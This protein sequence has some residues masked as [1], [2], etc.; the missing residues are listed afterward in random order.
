[1]GLFGFA[2]A[3]LGFAVLLAVGGTGVAATP[4]LSGAPL[5]SSVM[6]I[7]RSILA[8]LVRNI[9]RNIGPNIGSKFGYCIGVVTSIK[10]L[11][12]CVACAS[13]YGSTCLNGLTMTLLYTPANA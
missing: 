3:G 13:N 8:K 1:M 10:S 12:A 2:V 5:M 4:A 9:G 11:K 6:M 7:G